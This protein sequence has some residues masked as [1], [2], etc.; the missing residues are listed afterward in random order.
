MVTFDEVGGTWC[1]PFW[2][3]AEERLIQGLICQWWDPKLGE[4]IKKRGNGDHT[5]ISISSFRTSSLYRLR[6]VTSVT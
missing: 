3:L 4:T 6:T 1:F 2:V 5:W